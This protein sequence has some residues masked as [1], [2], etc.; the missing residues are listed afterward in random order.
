VKW[1]VGLRPEAITDLDEAASWYESKS[2]GLGMDFIRQVG[3]AISE[4]GLSPLIPRLRHRSAGI[5]WVYPRRFPY[6]IVYR[7]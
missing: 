7:G 2:V 6:R 5:R 1:R 3:V 4:L